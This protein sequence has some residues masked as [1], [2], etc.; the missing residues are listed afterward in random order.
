MRLRRRDVDM[1]ERCGEIFCRLYRREGGGGG[2][3][4]T[5]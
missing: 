1:A 2:G 3:S 5:V 4:G